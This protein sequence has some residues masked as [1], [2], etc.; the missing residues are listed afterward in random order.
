MDCK[1]ARLLTVKLLLICTL[2]VGTSISPVPLARSSKL[3]LLFVVVTKLSSINISPF[4]NSPFRVTLPVCVVLLVCVIVPV[5]PKSLFK[6][7]VPLIVKSCSNVTSVSLTN[8]LRS[9]TRFKSPLR[10]VVSI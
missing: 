8:I 2:L 4:V 3:L 10:L 6:I 7:V 9:E 1:S 5:I